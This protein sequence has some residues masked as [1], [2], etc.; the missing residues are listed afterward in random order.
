MILC[1]L[2]I[3]LKFDSGLVSI[4]G[5]DVLVNLLIVCKKIGFLFSFIG[6]YGCLLGR[7]NIVYFG[8][9]YGID[10]KVIVECIDEMVDLFD[11]YSFFDRCVENFFFG[12]K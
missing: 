11:M 6:L 3:V 9:L 1:I 5:E 10:K 8:E 7:E 12:M 2:L 4:D